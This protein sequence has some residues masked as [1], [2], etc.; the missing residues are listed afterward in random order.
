MNPHMPP[1]PTY[2]PI[3]SIQAARAV[4]EAWTDAGPAPAIHHAAAA[5]L[6]RKWPAIAGPLD[7][8]ALAEGRKKP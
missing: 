1:R 3:A 2:D 7:A 6:R 5:E 8:Y 4:L